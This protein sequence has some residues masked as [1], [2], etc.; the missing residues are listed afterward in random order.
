[1][2]IPTV[3]VM[4]F[5]ADC[6]RTLLFQRRNRPIKD[7]WYSLGG[8]LRKNERLVR[9]RPPNAQLRAAR[10]A[11]ASSASTGCCGASGVR[12]SPRAPQVAAATRIAA[13]ETGLALAPEQLRRGQTR[14]ACSV[15]P[16]RR[17]PPSSVCGGVA[18]RYGGRGQCSSLLHKVHM[19]H[20]CKVHIGTIGM[21][22]PGN[23]FIGDN[24]AFLCIPIR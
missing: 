24:G 2:P 7:V 21:V 15:P 1:M 9:R 11:R 18:I 5:S 17:T 23:L 12:L 16:L 13:G 4:I 20:R 14:A 6:T 22:Y 8:R 19:S 3:D 10:L